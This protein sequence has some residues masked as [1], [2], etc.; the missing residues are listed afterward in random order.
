MKQSKWYNNDGDIYHGVCME[1]TPHFAA[2]SAS[3]TSRDEEF[4][5]FSVTCSLCIDLQIFCD[6]HL[7]FLFSSFYWV[8]RS[9]GSS[10]ESALLIV[11]NVHVLTHFMTTSLHSWLVLQKCIVPNVAN[12]FQSG[13]FW[14]ISSASCYEDILVVFSNPPEETHYA[15]RSS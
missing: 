14:A 1:L 11:C 5:G 12:S 8:L 15:T 10:V 4:S 13:Q 2:V 9:K 6:I 7:T 3:H